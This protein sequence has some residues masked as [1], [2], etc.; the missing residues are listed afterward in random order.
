MSYFIGGE[1]YN[2][3][4]WDLVDEIEKYEH[5]LDPKR[6]FKRIGDDTEAW[7]FRLVMLRAQRAQMMA[8]RDAGP[9]PASSGN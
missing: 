5:L 8:Q 6:L 2:K 9:R 4:Y 7:R 3:A 1:E